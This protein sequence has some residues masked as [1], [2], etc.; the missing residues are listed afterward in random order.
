LLKFEKRLANYVTLKPVIEDYGLGRRDKMKVAQFE[1]FWG[2][3]SWIIPFGYI[4]SGP[5]RSVHIKEIAHRNLYMDRGLMKYLLPQLPEEMV[6]TNVTFGKIGEELHRIVDGLNDLIG[7]LFKNKKDVSRKFTGDKSRSAMRKRVNEFLDRLEYESLSETQKEK[8]RE[9]GIKNKEEFNKRKI[10]IK[11]SLSVIYL[12]SGKNLFWVKREYGAAHYGKKRRNVYVSA[13][14][15]TRASPDQVYEVVTHDVLHILGFSHQQALNIA[16]KHNISYKAQELM[17]ELAKEDKE[18]DDLTLKGYLDSIP[19]ASESSIKLLIF[20]W[21]NVLNR[22]D[23]KIATEKLAERF[24]IDRKVAYDFYE[25]RNTDRNNPLYQYEHGI[26]DDKK[27]QE[28]TSNWLRQVTGRKIELSEADLK[29]IFAEWV[30]IGDI[31]EALSLLQVLR[32]KGYKVRILTTTS[33]IHH[34]FRLKHTKVVQLLE[35][36]EKDI[37][38]S[39]LTGLSKPDPRSYAK[40]VAD[41]GLSSGQC[42]FIDDRQ[43]CKDGAINAGLIGYLFNPHD[44]LGSVRD[45]TT[46]LSSARTSPVTPMSTKDLRVIIE[47]IKGKRVHAYTTDRG[48]LTKDKKLLTEFASLEDLVFIVMRAARAH[49]RNLSEPISANQILE[50]VQNVQVWEGRDSIKEDE[51][52]YFG[53]LGIVKDLTDKCKTGAEARGYL[54]RADLRKGD[55]YKIAS[56]TLDQ[57]TREMSLGPVVSIS[58]QDIE[59][60]I[61]VIMQ[62]VVRRVENQRIQDLASFG[63]TIAVSLGGTK[64][65]CAAVNPAGD[66]FARV[67][68]IKTPVESDEVLFN[69]IWSQ[70][71]AIAST[72]GFEKVVGIGVSSPGPLNPETGV[73]IESENIPFKNFPLKNRL[74]QAFSNRFGRQVQARVFHDADARAK[75]E[76]SAKGTLPGCQNMMFLNWGTGIGNGVI[77]DGKVYWNDPVVGTMIGEPGYTVTKTKDGKYRHYHFMKDR[78]PAPN[79]LAEGEVY[80]EHYLGGPALIQ[81]MRQQISQSGTG[82]EALLKTVNKRTIQDLELKDINEAGRAGNELA[83]E[84]IEE[85]GIELG[86]GLAAFI[87]YWKLERGEKFTDNVIIGAGVAKIGNGVV[88]RDRTG[89]EIPV[90]PEA[91]KEGL[92][93]ELGSKVSDSINV[94]ISE[95]VMSEFDYDGELLAFTPRIEDFVLSSPLEGINIDEAIEGLK[96]G[97]PDVRLEAVKKIMSLDSE[98][99]NMV[100]GHFASLPISGRAL[101]DAAKVL[102]V[103]VPACNIDNGELSALQIRAIMEAASEMNALIIFEVGPGALKTYAKGK[104]HLPEY[105]ARVARELYRE[106][107]RKVTYIVHLDHNQIDK[108]KFKKDP[109]GA[110]QEAIDRARL[111]LKVGFTSFATDTS[112]L[113]DEEVKRGDFESEE[114]YLHARLK[115]VI[116]TGIEIIRVIEEG[117]EELGIEVGHEGEVGD[118]GTDISTFEEAKYYHEHLKKRLDVIAEQLGTSHGYDFTEDDKLKPYEGGPITVDDYYGRDTTGQI[119]E[120]RKKKGVVVDRA[121]ETVERFERELGIKIGVALRGFSGTPLEVV[122]AFVGTGIAKVN[123]NTDWQAITWKVLQA[124]YP[125]LYRRCFD[126][127]RKAAIKELEKLREKENKEQDSKEKEKLLKKIEKLEKL[128]ELPFE[129]SRNRI[130][131]GKDGAPG[132]R[133][134]FRGSEEKPEGWKLLEEITNTLKQTDVKMRLPERQR[135]EDILNLVLTCE[136]DDKNGITS[137]EAIHK[138]TKERIHALMDRMNLRDSANGVR[139]IERMRECRLQQWQLD[140]IR[141]AL[142]QAR[143]QTSIGPKQTEQNVITPRR[144]DKG[145]FGPKPGKSPRDAKKVIVSSRY[146]QEVLRKQGWFSLEHYVVAYEWEA[147]ELGF[148]PLAKNWRSTARRD[149]EGLAQQ[150]FLTIDESGKVQVTPNGEREIGVI[151]WLMRSAESIASAR[152]NVDIALE[153]EDKDAIRSLLET[154]LQPGFEKFVNRI[155]S[156]EILQITLEILEAKREIIPEPMKTYLGESIEKIRQRIQLLT[157][158][159][160]NSP[161][162]ESNASLTEEKVTRIKAVTTLQVYEK[163][164]ELIDIVKPVEPVTVTEMIEMLRMSRDIDMSSLSIDDKPIELTSWKARNAIRLILEEKGLAK[165]LPG[166]L[167]RNGVK[168]NSP[169]DKRKFFEICLETGQG[170]SPEVLQLHPR[171]EYSGL[172]LTA[173]IV[174]DLISFSS[175]LDYGFFASVA[176]ENEVKLTYKDKETILTIPPTLDSLTKAFD[177]LLGDVKPEVK[178]APGFRSFLLPILVV[179]LGLASTGWTKEIVRTIATEERILEELSNSGPAWSA[180]PILVFLGIGLLAGI[181]VAYKF[182]KLEMKDK[183][184]GGT[185]SKWFML[186]IGSWLL[187]ALVGGRI[188]ISMTKIISESAISPIPQ[189]V[190]QRL[191]LIACSL[192]GYVFGYILSSSVMDWQE[193]KQEYQI[194]SKLALDVIVEKFSADE[195]EHI[196]EQMERPTFKGKVTE[197]KV[198]ELY[199]LLTRLKKILDE[200]GVRNRL[201]EKFQK[202]KQIGGLLML[203]EALAR[204][205]L[206]QDITPSPAASRILSINERTGRYIRRQIEEMDYEAHTLQER[207][208][209]LREMMESGQAYVNRFV[210]FIKIPGLLDNT[211]EFAHIGLG[212]TY[213][214]TVIYIDEGYAHNEIVEGHEDK[215]IRLWENALTEKLRGKV[216]S[217]AKVRRWMKENL[218]EAIALTKEFHDE[219]NKEYNIDELAREKGVAP[220]KW[221]IEELLAEGAYAKRALPEVIFRKPATGRRKEELKVKKEALDKKFGKWSNSSAVNIA[222]EIKKEMVTMFSK[223]FDVKYFIGSDLEEKD[224]SMVVDILLDSSVAFREFK[225]KVKEA[226]EMV[227]YVVGYGRLEDHLEI[228]PPIFGKF[229]RIAG[230]IK[231][232]EL[233]KDRDWL[234]KFESLREELDELTRWDFLNRF[235]DAEGMVLWRKTS[236]WDRDRY[237]RT[238]LGL[239]K[240][241]TFEF[242]DDFFT[243]ISSKNIKLEN[244]TAGGAEYPILV[245]Y[246]PL[247]SIRLTSWLL[248]EIEPEVVVNGPAEYMD[249]MYIDNDDDVERLDNLRAE[250]ERALFEV[251]GLISITDELSFYEQGE[252]PSVA[253]K[254]GEDYGQYLEDSRAFTAPPGVPVPV[255]IEF[256][257]DAFKNGLTEE[258]AQGILN[259][260]SRQDLQGAIE[261]GRAFDIRLSEKERLHHKDKIL[262]VI[263]LKPVTYKG[264]P[265]RMEAYSGVEEVGTGVMLQPPFRFGVDS[266]RRICIEPA[267]PQPVGGQYLDEE[268]NEYTEMGEA[269]Q[270]GFPTAYPIGVGQFIGMVFEGKPVGFVIMALENVENKRVGGSGLFNKVDKISLREGLSIE[271]KRSRIGV[272]FSEFGRDLR[273]AARLLRR[274]HEEIGITHAQPHVENFAKLRDDVRLY[275]FTGAKSIRNMTREEFILRVINDFRGFYGSAYASVCAMNLEAYLAFIKNFKIEVLPLEELVKNYFTDKDRELIGEA[276]LRKATGVVSF[277]RFIT[278]VWIKDVVQGKTLEEL[279]EYEKKTIGS[280]LIGIFE[281]IAGPIYDKLT[282]SPGEKEQASSSSPT[283]RLWSLLF[284]GL[285][286]SLFIYSDLFA[287]VGKEIMRSGQQAGWGEIFDSVFGLGL[288]GILICAVI[289]W[290]QRPFSV[291]SGLVDEERVRLYE[292]LGLEGRPWKVAPTRVWQAL[293]SLFER[294]WSVVAPGL[295]RASKSEKMRMSWANLL[296]EPELSEEEIKRI[297]ALAEK[298]RRGEI[299]RFWTKRGPYFANPEINP[300]LGWT[301]PGEERAEEV[302]EI[303]EFAESVREDYEYVVVMGRA[304]P[305]AKLAAGIAE[306][307]RYP[308]VLALEA[309]PEALRDIENKISLEK[310]L[311]VISPPVQ[312]EGY[313]AYKYLYGKLTEFYKGEGVSA[314]EI[315]SELGKHFVGIVEANRPFAKEAGEK[316]FLRVFTEEQGVSRS[317][318]SYEGLV[319]LALAGVNIERFLESGKKGKAM[320]GEENLEKNLGMQLALFQEKMKESG[321]EIFIVLPEGMEG[322]GQS[323]QELVESL[324][325]EGERITAV[326][327]G[328]LSSPE[329]YGENAAFIVVR[330]DGTLKSARPVVGRSPFRVTAELRKAGY[331]VF[332]IPLRGKEAIGELFYRGEFATALSYLMRIDR[333]R[334]SVGGE[335]ASSAEAVGYQ[336]EEVLSQVAASFSL[337]EVEPL[338]EYP[339]RPMVVKYNGTKVFVFDFES[340]F[341]IE[342]VKEA[343]PS[344]MDIE[345]KVKPRSRAVFKVMEKVVKAAKEM[346][347]LDGVKFAFVSSRRNVSG[348]VMEE[349]LRDYMSGYGLKAEV[350]SRV[351]DSDLVIDR[352]ELEENGGIVGISKTPKISTKAVFNIINERLLLSGRSDGN[353]SEIKIITDRESRWAK[354]GKREMMERILWVLLEPAKEGEMLSS[355]A[356]LVVAI[357]GKVSQWLIEFIKARYSEEEAERLL[358]RIVKD[359]KIILPAIPVDK[360]Y[361]EGIKSEERIYKVQA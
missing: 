16:K 115:D 233:D 250:Y 127:A 349:M 311:F 211:G 305:Y 191:Y 289:K 237:Q 266:S 106:T 172:N 94:V 259:V 201:P 224:D 229:G 23:Y 316:E 144:A 248:E 165:S 43:D 84:L 36:G 283:R 197:G 285:V 301:Y 148:E 93:R 34:E 18:K 26:I 53:A 128:V 215:E 9:S 346:G 207:K 282:M 217:L 262:K 293:V 134:L 195:L 64:I 140:E 25:R 271:K 105:C 345:L 164:K 275:D 188:L 264:Q 139:D 29:E 161:A 354:D 19:P 327:E 177:E 192:T 202:K 15:A 1:K 333:F 112:T 214:E 45:I 252:T 196:I 72:V 121:R 223:V 198:P 30:L 174:T 12:D 170:G 97:N 95:M 21:G 179:V 342:P 234:T 155:D 146:L 152:A 287:A 7:S 297:R 251:E 3:A 189:K 75:G 263:R 57:I 150:G 17:D 154:H 60:L 158:Q 181:L 310:T 307:K 236:D 347:N 33:K 175:L 107:G 190:F 56:A 221:G 288:W 92:R 20:D 323:W 300:W 91:I 247:E 245:A 291:R 340:L 67:P 213:G 330:F 357:E 324:W 360:K 85:A 326:T 38:A 137:Q 160:C 27:L 47:A 171:G 203:K 63:V 343:T 290:G 331:P 130:I 14:Y 123:I 109:R 86:R 108:N 241:K 110:L 187:A 88:K 279:K 210:A 231:M 99:K 159:N 235:P 274:L 329:K 35:N 114:D 219:A 257:N 254:S 284:G 176:S 168:V 361:L 147:I 166:K 280:D 272:E 328:E 278:K 4:L 98:L 296:I 358:S 206:M 244:Y 66:I 41:A 304:V 157:T 216:R 319:P 90:L 22:Y 6:R 44:I 341:D 65:G 273:M 71:E 256:A 50:Y 260:V 81:R 131:F 151:S 225:M 180:Y 298:L 212:Q 118:I 261:T 243:Y 142:E 76:V 265:P 184:M 61:K 24:G 141:E 117:A 337:R 70:I 200:I 125:D 350:V 42:L 55:A 5:D 58:T 322:F 267:P 49:Y 335:K 232:I 156:V 113:T 48:L 218:K 302:R 277:D 220:Y 8:L 153:P 242:K 276:R 182:K 149:L 163:L 268:I 313:E 169:V 129:K 119:D 292:A 339:V 133:T 102:R 312:G 281:E 353:G 299:A 222:K 317:I 101:F 208:K 32:K 186:G 78:Y 79:E 59:R 320:C 132:L 209:V 104:P 52:D 356:G 359:G 325:G 77:R 68:D 318:F 162:E 193:K 314:E 205:R 73:I 13:G 80:F 286:I 173:E 2:D 83:T 122:L 185:G 309:R 145:R 143:I 135:E 11:K 167:T 126:L 40:V 96:S 51:S 306:G 87:K 336:R 352:R 116:E 269:F 255:R 74:E 249:S 111:T 136:R 238:Y 194:S 239:D 82:S 89:K 120:K 303:G 253:A 54:G 226:L 227:G 69:A 338:S 258:V 355:A 240:K 199:K 332:E 230:K 308:Q 31:P 10:D 124:Y 228:T 138:L 183:M 103:P 46:I 334:R 270:K 348:E 344:R 204:R 39:Y 246:V 178:P 351:I 294:G 315:T 321:R 37:Y 295:H 28:R 62:E 100:L